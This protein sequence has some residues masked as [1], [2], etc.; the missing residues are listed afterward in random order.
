MGLLTRLLGLDELHRLHAAARDLGEAPFEDRALRILG[1]ETDAGGLNHIPRQGA[2]LVVANHPHGALDGLALLSIVRRVRPD[3]RALASQMLAQIP[4]M[5]RSCF[6]VDPFDRP[7]AAERSRAG[8]R[9]AH[10]WLRRGGAVIVFPAGEVA[11]RRGPGPAREESTWKGAAGRLAAASRATI[12]PASIDGRNS[13][14]FYAAGAV[15][16]ALRT[17]LLPRELLRKRQ[18]SLSVRF[19]RPLARAQALKPVVAETPADVLE[20]EIH[21]L[22]ADRCLVDSGPFQVFCADAPQIPAALREIGRLREETYRGVGEGT[23]REVDLDEFDPRYQH[24]FVWDLRARLIAGAYRIGRTDRILEER[25]VDGLYTRRLFRFDEGLF[26]NRPPALELGRSFVRREYQRHSNVLM[27][28][29]RGIGQFVVRHPE[30]RLLFGPVSVS[31]RYSDM[32]QALLR[33]FLEQNHRHDAFAELVQGLHPPRM[34]SGSRQ[35][36]VPASVAE[37]DALIRSYEGDGKGVPVLLRQYLKLN[38]RLLGFNVDSDFGD[39]LDALMMVDLADVDPAIIT[40]YFG[41][42][43]AA[44]LGL[45]GAVRPAAP[46]AAA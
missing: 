21:A 43:D 27:L 25:G 30:Y 37:V 34:E 35:T 36:Q 32:S 23:G 42:E 1:V 6:F 38:A 20:R 22:P 24:L 44:R 2:V 33:S 12:V 10:L 19:H 29:W 39:A 18:T 16:P 8:L 41:R 45:P 14:L 17:A 15:H 46:A 3:V 40:R 7:G 5:H 31:T 26:R 13:L 4:E 9:A 11:H 28:L